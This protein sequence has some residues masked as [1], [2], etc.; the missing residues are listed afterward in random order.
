MIQLKTPHEIE[1]MRE[2]CRISAGA[3]AEA[4]KY[5]QPGVTT[6]EID[7][8]VHKYIVSMGAKPNFL[9]YAGYP[10]SACISI[11]NQVIHGI[12]SSRVVLKEGDIVSVDTGAYYNGFNG[13]NAYT[14]AV[15]KISPEAEQLLKVTQECLYKAID[16]ARVGNRIGDIGYACQSHAEKFGYGVVRT[17]V[18]HGV[19]RKLHEDP[20]VPN[21]GKP[22]RGV[23]L[24]AGMTLAIEPMINLVGDDVVTLEDGWTVE[25]V[26]GSISAHFE[27]SIVVTESDPIILTRI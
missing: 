17:Y 20:E 15:G 3:L 22:G 16:A 24:A 2:A 19:G 6:K 18:G 26:S 7:H 1:Q 9:G 14:F 23:R 10:G 13:D 11:N 27:H 21:Y 25:T 4:G 8:A 12:P 5:M